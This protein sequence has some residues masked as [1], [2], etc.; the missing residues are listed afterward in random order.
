MSD[1]VVSIGGVICSA[2]GALFYVLSRQ[3]DG[4][5]KFLASARILERLDE[6]LHLE[7]A[8]PALVALRGRADSTNP[9]P[10]ELS[11]AKAVFHE[12]IEE[13][14]LITRSAAGHAVRNP[15]ETRR[16][17]FT[18]DWFLDDGSGPRVRVEGSRGAA[19]RPDAV[20]TR[21]DYREKP[22]GLPQSIAQFF[23]EVG[24]GER[25]W[26]PDALETRQD[27]REKPEGL[28]QSIAQFF[29]GHKTQGYKRKESFVPV[30][31]ILTVVGELARNALPGNGGGARFV[32]RPPHPRHPY[33]ISSQRP[34]QLRAGFLRAARVYKGIALA[35]GGLGAY[36]MARRAL[37]RWL[38]ARRE[39]RARR[40][41]RDAAAARE[42]RRA[43]LAAGGGGADGGAGDD[44]EADTCVVC[45]EG[46]ADMVFVACGHLCACARCSKQLRK[47]PVCRKASECIKVF[48]M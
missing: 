4:H 45:L 28:P 41:L 34:E 39:A 47:C 37:A 23:T 1:S 25:A 3:E 7:G 43:A 13:D 30:G 5:A 33:Y 2:V 24:G 21:Q 6:A 46:S 31:A 22:E 29:T 14:I 32:V 10:C 48:R 20:E 27:Y 8:L 36:L 9:K 12:L 38:R 44:R 40:A 18:A 35:F 11:D 15:F 19:W 16:E 17:A 42:A 26:R